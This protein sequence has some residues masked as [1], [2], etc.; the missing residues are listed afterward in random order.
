MKRTLKLLLLLAVMA[1]ALGLTR[2][3]PAVAGSGP[4][5]TNLWIPFPSGSPFDE[6]IDFSGSIHLVIQA[7]PS[8]PT[9]PS[10]PVRISTNLAGVTGV[11]QT[12]GIG[13]RVTGAADFVLAASPNL[14]FTAT[15]RLI[16]VDPIIPS[17]PLR[18]RFFVSI[19]ADG[20]VG[21]V[22][23]EIAPSPF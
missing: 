16:P 21:T 19:L 11:G 12:S 22:H 6:P 4:V 2:W 5:T 17:D 18:V 1:G 3:T 23:T 10:D 7:I 9:I 15:Y 14:D 13:Y 20:S 8:D